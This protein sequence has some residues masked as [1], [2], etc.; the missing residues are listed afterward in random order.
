M[1]RQEKSEANAVR[2]LM[3]IG[4]L[5]SC[6]FCML[7]SGALLNMPILGGALYLTG[8]C[9]LLFASLRRASLDV[10][11]RSVRRVGAALLAALALL[12]LAMILQCHVSLSD[13]A[14]WRLGGVVLCMLLRLWLTRYVRERASA[15]REKAVRVLCVQWLFLM[16]V[17]LLLSSKDRSAAFALS[18]GCVVSGILEAF[19]PEHMGDRKRPLSD[20]DKQEIAALDGA[21]AYRVFQ[22]MMVA[23]A[24]ALQIT[25]VMAYT[26]MAFT[27]D[28]P[29]LCIGTALLCVCAAVATD[30][31]LRRGKK[32]TDPYFLMKTG[33]AVWLLGLILF[34]R[35]L[36]APVIACLSLALCAVGATVCV[37]VIAGLMGDMSQVAAFVLDREPG[38]AA[39]LAQ[40]V[41]FEVGALFGQMAALAA[42]ILTGIFTAVSTSGG[43]TAFH[44][45]SPLFT[46]PALFLVGAAIL[47]TLRFPLTQR[48]LDKLRRYTA[49]GRAG[50]ENAP[51][52]DQL[53]AVIVKKSRKRYGIKA[54][55]WTLWPLCYHRVRGQEKVKLDDDVPCVFVCNHGE[56]YGP[57]VATLYIPFSFRTWVTYEMMDANIIAENAMNGAFQKVK[58]PWRKI[59]DWIMRKLGAPFVAWIMKSLDSIPVYHDNPRGLMQTFRETVAAMQTGD[60]ILIFPENSETSADHKYAREGVSEFFTGFTMIGQLYCNKTGKCPLFVPLYADKH[61]RVITFGTPTRYDPDAPANEEKERLC[62]YLRGEM[63][64][65]AGMNQDNRRL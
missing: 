59:L 14:F 24:A 7:A 43:D 32:E 26:Y 58:G 13:P 8:Q 28:A 1:L 17:I 50:V 53:E 64:K 6:L 46:L 37:R 52:H 60:N 23:A 16:L 54:V 36:N 55:I 57:V 29:L 45:F 39:E 40:Q 30:A 49:L 3:T 9:A 51:L 48:H 65:I 20:Q 4:T 19:S 35:F 18:A 42:L 47:F 63:L 56:I 44:S 34:I 5:F 2:G 11:S 27:Y 10:V 21:R 41:R 12:F 61:K 33:L 15:A 31:L 25:Q 38:G 62:N 22:G